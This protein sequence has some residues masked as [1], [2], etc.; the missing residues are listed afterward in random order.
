MEDMTENAQE[1]TN[2]TLAFVD[3]IDGLESERRKKW[4][5]QTIIEQLPKLFTKI[6]LV[7]PHPTHHT[8]LHEHF[9]SC[10]LK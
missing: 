9:G 8:N 3:T 4:V 5:T 10:S 2:K 7:L 6:G 1:L